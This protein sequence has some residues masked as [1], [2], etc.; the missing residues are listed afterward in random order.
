MTRNQ[1]NAP[2]AVTLT[3]TERST[4]RRRAARGSHERL[5]I[6]AIL[7][8]ALVCHLGVSLEDGP[9]VL[10]TAHVRCG[11]RVYVHGARKNHLLAA[12]AQGIPATLTVTLIDGLVFSREAFH[13][14][15]N[16]RS[17]VL[18]GRA[19]EVHDPGEKLSAL[20]ALVERTA[21]GRFDEV[22]APTPEE[23]ASTLVLAFPIQEGSA[24][25]RSGPPNDGAATAGRGIW[26]GVVPLALRA[27]VP[28]ADALDAVAPPLSSAVRARTQALGLGPRAPYERPIGELLVS[29]D[30]GRLDHAL[31]HRFLSDESYWAS[32]VSA[33][34][35]RASCD[36]ALCF[37]VYRGREQLAF[38]RV[39]TD[40]VRIAYLGD[41]FV[42]AE[43]RGQGL[44][45]R[46]VAEILAHPDLAGV[47]RWLLGTRDAHGL[48]TRFGFVEAP[49]GRYMV[50]RRG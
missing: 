50:R 31:V 40:F 19:S 23:L 34:D 7:D 21:P 47:E 37:G 48:Y 8:E 10:P 22:I 25:V 18:F 32:G 4:P 45:K 36:Q 39:I 24:K 46:L 2:P 26:A 17:V 9:H 5:L 11:D 28:V 20:R 42:V 43:A 16:Y 12:A 6:D 14:S 27:G 35:V 44:S 3:P 13:H 33:P 15:M 30:P 1:E 38:A 49:A 29:T 41:V